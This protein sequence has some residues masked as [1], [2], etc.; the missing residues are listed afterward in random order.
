MHENGSVVRI[1]GAPML[2]AI[3]TSTVTDFVSD[4]PAEAYGIVGVVV[5]LLVLFLL[6]RRRHAKEADQSD[7][8]RALSSGGGGL[9]RKE[10]RRGKREEKRMVKCDSKSEKSR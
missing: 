1:L 7:A 2:V 8:G 3:D 5:L 6:V 10:A 9:S 4:H